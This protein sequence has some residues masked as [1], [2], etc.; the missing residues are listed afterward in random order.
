MLH[1]VTGSRGQQVGGSY[2]HLAGL[3]VGNSNTVNYSCKRPASLGEE[4]AYSR[5][6]GNVAGDLTFYGQSRKYTIRGKKNHYTRTIRGAP[7]PASNTYRLLP[8]PPLEHATSHRHLA[9]MVG[10]YNIM[11]IF[12]LLGTDVAQCS[13]TITVPGR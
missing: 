6:L 9:Q 13:T 1:S 4:N 5:E 11:Q 3:A 7:K 12:F 2:T 8:S 10:K